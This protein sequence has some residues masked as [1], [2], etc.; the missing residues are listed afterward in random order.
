MRIK[1]AWLV[2]LV[3]GLGL[4]GCGK[5]HAAVPGP[6]T[7]AVLT[8]TATVLNP[9]YALAVD[10]TRVPLKRGDPLVG[11]FA[12]GLRQLARHCTNPV[13]QLALMTMET[14]TNEFKHGIHENLLSILR[15]VS[16]RVTGHRR[17][18]SPA[19]AAFITHR[20]GREANPSLP[21]LG[22]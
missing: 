14:R 11:Q 18:C 4:I 13:A 16:Q 20:E 3:L 10:Q 22:P 6:A 9:A 17:D 5:P 19:F 7:V 8:A 21:P 1:Q 15:A 2:L 12:H